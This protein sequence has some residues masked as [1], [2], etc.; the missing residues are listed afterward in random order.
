LACHLQ[1]NADHP[2]YH[3]DA[4]PDADFYLMQMR[5]QVTKMKQ[6]RMLIGS[7]TLAESQGC[8]SGSPHESVYFGKLD[9]VWCGFVLIP[10]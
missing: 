2:A 4:D 10:F 7:T 6:I 9:P 5:I 1:I 8:G 3:F